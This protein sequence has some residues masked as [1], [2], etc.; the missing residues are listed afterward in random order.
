MP[1]FSVDNSIFLPQVV[2]LIEEGHSATIIARG[3][4]MRPFIEDGRDKLVLGKADS[5]KVA[6]NR[7]C[8]RTQIVLSLILHEFIRQTASRTIR[9]QFKVSLLKLEV[10]LCHH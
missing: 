2:R 1:K 9:L 7:R 6:G 3:D 10:I 5:I 4:S 8:S